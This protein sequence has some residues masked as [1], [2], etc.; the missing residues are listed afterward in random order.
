VTLKK[1]WS[2]IRIKNCGNNRWRINGQANSALR[3][4]PHIIIATPGRL[5]DM[6][7]SR[8]VNLSQVSVLVLDEADRMLDMGFAP[9]LNKIIP[10]LQKKDRR[11]F[12]PRLWIKVS[13]RLQPPI[14]VT[15]AHRSRA[16]WLYHKHDY[17]VKSSWS[18]K[19]IA[20]APF[21]DLH[22]HNRQHTCLSRTNMA[23][24]KLPPYSKKNPLHPQKFILTG[25]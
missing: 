23:H 10:H 17:S 16:C 11:C 13:L 18:A 7:D 3:L 12:F 20:S 4:D 14:C 24:V 19:M 5:I 6:I 21:K 9:Q 1:D 15:N 2:L 25:L 8:K 22:E